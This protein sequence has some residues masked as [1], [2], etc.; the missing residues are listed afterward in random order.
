[1]SMLDK[2]KETFSFT[3]P[4]SPHPNAA[5]SPEL[6]NQCVQEIISGKQHSAETRYLGKAIRAHF[7]EQLKP[8]KQIAP[9]LFST[10]FSHLAHSTAEAVLPEGAFHTENDAAIRHI[11]TKTLEHAENNPHGTPPSDTITLHQVLHGLPPTPGAPLLP[12]DTPIHGTDVLGN[13]VVVL[14]GGHP[15]MEDVA[16]SNKKHR[17]ET[18]YGGDD[19][20]AWAR[21]TWMSVLMQQK[22]EVLAEEIKNLGPEFVEVAELTKALAH[23]LQNQGHDAIIDRQSSPEN[24]S[25][26]KI[27]WP[28]SADA[29]EHLQDCEDVLKQITSALTSESLQNPKL[30]ELPEGAPLDNAKIFLL[31]NVLGG[32]AAVLTNKPTSGQRSK[33]NGG[34]RSLCL[35]Q[36][37]NDTIIDRL[38]SADVD[39]RPQQIYDHVCKLPMIIQDGAGYGVEFV[40][41]PPSTDENQD[42]SADQN[43]SDKEHQDKAEKSTSAPSPTSSTPV[44]TSAS[45]DKN[46]T[47]PSKAETDEKQWMEKEEADNARVVSEAKASD[48][49]KEQET[50]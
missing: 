25:T 26:F 3:S 47:R 43:D 23:A 10:G 14:L 1:M 15:G 18:L 41:T 17:G 16:A 36:P 32:Q 22:P 35:S 39:R 24:K 44:P 19:S 11:L 27:K 48:L 46:A 40:C 7:D 34:R 9:G 8:R 12:P 20:W 13:K 50:L 33:S 28:K 21:V 45:D 5:T 30:K 49:K 37:D 4:K 38:G 42:A 6:F 2:L 31:T 29:N